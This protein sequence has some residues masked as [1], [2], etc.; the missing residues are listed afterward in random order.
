MSLDLHLRKLIE[1]ARSLPAQESAICLEEGDYQIII[2][3]RRSNDTATELEDLLRQLD[4]PWK[5]EFVEWLRSG[6]S[7]TQAAELAGITPRHAWRSRKT[8]GVLSRAWAVA[9]EAARRASIRGRRRR[10]P[11]TDPSS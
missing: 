7:V 2:L 11:D 9:R 10:H 8:D 5:C 4:A 3:P 6:R 1:H